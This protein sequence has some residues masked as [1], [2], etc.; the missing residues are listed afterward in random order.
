MDDLN[1][2]SRLINNDTNKFYSQSCKILI[3]FKLKVRNEFFFL[4]KNENSFMK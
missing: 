4:K 3:H 1:D 2:F